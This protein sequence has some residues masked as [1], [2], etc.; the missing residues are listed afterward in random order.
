MKITVLLVLAVLSMTGLSASS[1]DD[2]KPFGLTTL[3]GETFQHCR[4]IKVTPEAITVSH[5]SGV[6]KIPFEHL[7]DEWK[8][9]FHYSPEKADAFQKE[10]AVRRAIAEEKRRQ[11]RREYETLRTKQLGERRA[12]VSPWIEKLAETIARQQVEAATAA[13][14]ATP[15]LPGL[16]IPR[17][18]DP[19]PY[20]RAGLLTSRTSTPGSTL[21]SAA[22]VLIPATTPI[23]PVYTPDATPSQSYIINQGVLFTPGDGSIDYFNPG[24]IS[25]GYFIPGYVNP[26]YV[27]PG[28]V[29][30]PVRPFRPTTVCPPAVVRPGP[31]FSPVRP[32]VTPLRPGSGG[33]RPVR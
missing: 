4:I 20:S 19:T 14:F 6:S 33:F 7:S 11:A 29:V 30:P 28:Y 8:K 25:P 9:R 32:G 26:G 24:Y 3:L 5:D 13:A 17:P 31:A 21:P 1:G 2:Q 15:T 10:E 16:L 27:S 12:A 18:G 22:E 23:G